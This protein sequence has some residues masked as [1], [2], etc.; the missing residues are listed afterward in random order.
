MANP[1]IPPTPPPIQDPPPDPVVAVVTEPWTPAVDSA[2]PLVLPRSEYPPNP[3]APEPDG[4]VGEPWIGI[5]PGEPWTPV[6]RDCLRIVY[7]FTPN[8]YVSL[9]TARDLRGYSTSEKNKLHTLVGVATGLSVLVLFRFWNNNSVSEIVGLSM[10]LLALCMTY[11]WVALRE[12]FVSPRERFARESPLNGV[13]FEWELDD[14][15]I[16]VKVG[17]MLH[18]RLEWRGASRCVRTESGYFIDN[19]AHSYWI[20]RRVFKGVLNEFQFTR[21]LQKH[22]PACVNFKPPKCSK[23]GYDLR[24]S[25][26]T[27]G[28]SCPECGS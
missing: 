11:W 8:D 24:G 22:V 12:S 4:S 7:I 21:R 28:V 26:D 5:G 25:I 6:S 17:D 20:P 15:G 16:V 18:E 14:R 1:E 23:C 2:A 27:S 9:C 10:I 13:T 3:A 19:I